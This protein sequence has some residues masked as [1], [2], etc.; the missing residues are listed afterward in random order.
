MQQRRQYARV[1]TEEPSRKDRRKARSEKAE[2]Y[3]VKLHAAIWVVGALF[4]GYFT[5]IMRVCWESQEVHRF[6]FNAG[7]FCLTVSIS[8]V[9]YMAVYVPRVLKCDLEP[10]AYSPKLLPLTA[11]FSLAAGLF[12]I[13]GL[14]PVFG[15][16]T[17]G[18][19]FLL[20]LGGLMSAH[21][22]PA[23]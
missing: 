22:I 12:L 10:S 2:E 3:S 14:W 16:L 8:L 19:L 9:M 6:W 21:F 13:I 18:L 4:A 15:L 23:L 5:D 7:V 17:P 1:G 11:V 20:W